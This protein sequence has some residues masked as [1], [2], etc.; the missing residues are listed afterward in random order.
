M[1]MKEL[2]GCCFVREVYGP[3]CLRV[4]RHN[5]NNQKQS[6]KSQGWPKK[7][8]AAFCSEK[9]KTEILSS[10]LAG[11]RDLGSLVASVSPAAPVLVSS[12]VSLTA[13]F[14]HIKLI[15]PEIPG[16]LASSLHTGDSCQKSSLH[17]S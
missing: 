7:H 14:L 16:S 15:P 12:K 17:I 3:A 2:N 5:R 11:E 4:G 8:F 6:V 10:V 1:R 13:M 9:T